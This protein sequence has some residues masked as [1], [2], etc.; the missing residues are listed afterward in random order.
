MSSDHTDRSDRDAH[1]SSDKAP[2]TASHGAPPW[3]V[4]VGPWLPGTRHPSAGPVPLSTPENGHSGI[5][6]RG[7][8]T[9]AAL[10]A[11]AAVAWRPVAA[12]AFTG[13][14]GSGAV[15]AQVDLPDGLFTLGVGSGDPL[16]DRVV[17]W[18]RL[19]PNPLDGG[20]MPAVDVNVEWELASDEEFTDVVASGVATAPAAF[21]HSV[22][23]DAGAGPEGSLDPDTWYFYRFRVGEE[24]SPTGRTRTTPPAESSPDKLTFGF[25]SCQ[26][27]SAGF[28]W[29]YRSVAN[30]PDIDLMLF[31]GDYIYE[32]AGSG[33]RGFSE[34]EAKTLLGYRNRYA[35]YR[36]DTDLQAAHQRCPWVVVWDDH[37]VDNNYADLISQDDDPIEEFRVRRAEAYLAWWEHQA[38]RMPAPVDDTGTAVEDLE[39]YRSLQWGTL[40]TVFAIDGRQY[41]T[42][43]ANC[44]G[45]GLAGDALDVGEYCDALAEET[46]TML[47]FDQE[48]WLIEGLKASPTTWNVLAN[49]TVFASTPLNAFGVGPLFNSDQWDGYFA[50]RQRILDAFADPQVRNPLVVTGDIHASG[51]GYLLRTFDPD[52]GAGGRI[53]GHEFVGTSISSSF[54]TALAPLFSLVVG[55][56]DWLTYVNAEKRGYVLVELTDTNAT[57]NWKVVE[58]TQPTFS[59]AVVD[60]TWTIGAETPDAPPRFVPADFDDVAAN[61]SFATAVDWL[62]ANGI[63]TGV[64]NTNN[65][66][67]LG[68]VNRGQMAAFL[69]RM[70]GRPTVAQRHRFTDV[71]RTAFFDTGVSW[72]VANG[73]TEG[74]GSPT[75][76]QPQATVTRAQMAAFLWRMA[77]RPAVNEPHGFTDVPAEAFYEQPV[78][79]LKKWGITTGRTPETFDPQGLVNRAQMALFMYRMATTPQA[80][81][82]PLPPTAVVD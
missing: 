76:Y 56:L 60:H 82:V 4:T 35:R 5:G 73:I 26:N 51:A 80:W 23:V 69:W 3:D 50:S 18:T 48:Q 30:E 31:L 45:G 54:P 55:A 75:T 24:E 15:G 42:N 32:N 59:P 41:R 65:Y 7:F 43:Q 19:A 2:L 53:V 79:W 21:A 38:V 20:G 68:L 61:A 10:S 36:A 49:Q 47:G 71:A 16:E 57:G 8:L 67:P 63:T 25:A 39:I 58:A 22:H 70:A 62:K 77:G 11:A 33:P 78:R 29:A 17:L 9:G 12:A 40:A 1:R 74:L 64:G 27:Y 81:N 72:L 13:P 46:A 37:E 6:R 66:G 34:P 28:Y 44:G 52:R 14:S